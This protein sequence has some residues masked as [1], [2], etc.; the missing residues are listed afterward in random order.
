MK[1]SS[2]QRKLLAKCRVLKIQ[3]CPHYYIN[4]LY[5]F[6]VKIYHVKIKAIPMKPFQ[7]IF[8]IV[9]LQ[10]TFLP[11]SISKPLLSATQF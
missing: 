4:I 9:E 1:A 5:L 2:A 6:C 7:T 8:L 10:Q 11:L 3:M